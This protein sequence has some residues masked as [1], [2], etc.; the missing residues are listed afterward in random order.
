MDK[1]KVQAQDT[2]AR[3]FVA[4]ESLQAI[5]NAVSSIKDMNQQIATAA[6]EQAVVSEEINRKIVDISDIARETS[7]NTQQTIAT[8]QFLS[9]IANQLRT[10]MSRFKVA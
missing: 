8:G 1:G 4:T 2:V 10:L 9:V 5:P 3:S 7:T 6:E